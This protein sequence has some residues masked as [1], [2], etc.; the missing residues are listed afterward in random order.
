M[1]HPPPATSSWTSP[2]RFRFV[3]HDGAGQYSPV[4]DAVFEAAGI[5][6][7]TPTPSARG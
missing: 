2:D 3:I 6:P 7:I 5:E 4:F 1:D